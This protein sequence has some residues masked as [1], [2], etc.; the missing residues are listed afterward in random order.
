MEALNF[1]LNVATGPLCWGEKVSPRTQ[2]TNWTH[3]PPSPVLSFTY[4]QLII[5]NAVA[6][7]KRIH[8][9]QHILTAADVC[10]INVTSTAKRNMI[11]TQNIKNSSLGTQAVSA[12][13][14]CYTSRPLHKKVTNASLHLMVALWQRMTHMERPLQ[15]Q[16]CCFCPR[17]IK[18]SLLIQRANNLQYSLSPHSIACRQP[19]RCGFTTKREP[20]HQWCLLGKM[21]KHHPLRKGE[22]R[23]CNLHF[24]WLVAWVLE[25]HNILPYHTLSPPVL[26][27]VD[28]SS[29]KI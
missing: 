25:I 4:L 29:L 18:P 1:L 27:R 26:W 20:N 24:P 17:C 16:T 12:P 5:C 6:S 3:A 22:N 28:S 2:K 9:F 8:E 10:R 19:T 11:N 13:E 21:M 7:H 14:T 15:H 23:K